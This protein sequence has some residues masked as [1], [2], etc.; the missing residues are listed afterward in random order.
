MTSWVAAQWAQVSGSPF[1]GV[2][3]LVVKVDVI[4]AGKLRLAWQAE[5]PCRAEGGRATRNDQT[6]LGE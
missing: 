1:V 5:P 2:F 3:F 6:R 4:R